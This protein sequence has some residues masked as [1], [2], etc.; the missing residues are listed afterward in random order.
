MT[1]YL[2]VITLF[3]AFFYMLLLF[4]QQF[5]RNRAY[6]A[7]YDLKCNLLE[8]QVKNITSDKAKPSL[9][10]AAWSGWRKFRVRKIVEENATTKSFYFLPHDGK[11]LA[12]FLPGQHITFR[13]KVP[14]QSKPVIRC[15]SLSNSAK[16]TN[17]YRVTIKKQ[18]APPNKEGAPN[19]VSSCYFHNDLLK[20]DVLDVRAPSGKFYLDLTEKTPIVLIGGGIGLTPSLS[21]LN[22]LIDI[23][24]ERKIHFLYAVQGKEE[25]IMEAHFLAMEKK[26]KNFT[27]HRFY[28][29]CEEEELSETVHQGF[30]SC[31]LMRDIGIEFDAD[32]YI[33][34]PPPMMNAI[35]G[36]LESEGISQD[37]IHFESFG[38][39][40]VSKKSE[41]KPSD[42]SDS[43]AKH[44]ISFSLS[45]KNVEWDPSQGSVL[46]AAESVGVDIQSGCRAGSC[47][48][49]LTAILEGDVSYL[50]D[51]GLD[52]EKGSCL[53]CIAIPNG[54][55]KLHA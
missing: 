53:A 13:L 4:V 50:D 47:G 20:G 27:F 3:V 17:Y 23:G 22:T 12:G 26:L 31:P 7:S 54:P 21:M 40:S 51:A 29:A 24:S 6:Q 2:G 9:E 55:L 18:L 1:L 34:G 15:Y 28:S 48:T 11:S 41:V 33:C 8:R 14:G 5:Q 32:F 46:D 36:G 25:Q 30:I 42:V 19:G 52:I 49:C 44:S 37:R 35:V 38:P 43:S 10:E 16:K 45:D 39:A